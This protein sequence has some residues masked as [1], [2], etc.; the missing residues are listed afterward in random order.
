MI[1]GQVCYFDIYFV[2]Y[3]SVLK[4]INSSVFILTHHN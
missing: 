2:I 1:F 3:I 4:K